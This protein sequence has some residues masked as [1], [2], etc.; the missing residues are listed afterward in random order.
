MTFWSKW[1]CAVLL[2]LMTA[3]TTP[4]YGQVDLS[5]EWTNLYH[6]D[7][8]ERGPGPAIG[9]YLG[10]PINDAARSRAIAGVPRY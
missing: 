8:P 3:G 9:D 7:A 6:E 10:L 4:A 2:G 5:G 1:G